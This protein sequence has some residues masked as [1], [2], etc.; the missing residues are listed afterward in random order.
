MRLKAEG[1]N[2]DSDPEREHWAEGTGGE[3]RGQQT[4]VLGALDLYVLF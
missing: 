3:R 2:E 4:R 1:G